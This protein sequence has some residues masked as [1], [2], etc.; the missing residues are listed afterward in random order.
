[1]LRLVQSL[2]GEAFL[3]VTLTRSRTKPLRVNR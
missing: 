1:M 3:N 2:L